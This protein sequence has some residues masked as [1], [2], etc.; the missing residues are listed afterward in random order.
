[1]RCVRHAQKIK[2]GS[3]RF[4][5]VGKRAHVGARFQCSALALENT[6][7]G[8]VHAKR[9]S[10]KSCHEYYLA[11]ASAILSVGVASLSTSEPSLAEGE[12]GGTTDS[13]WGDEAKRYFVAQ[14][15]RERELARQRGMRGEIP[16]VYVDFSSEDRCVMKFHVSSE[17]GIPT[18]ASL[19]AALASSS[20][21]VE[22]ARCDSGESVIKLVDKSRN[23]AYVELCASPRGVVLQYETKGAI[24]SKELD[25]VASAYGISIQSKNQNPLAAFEMFNGE[26][27]NAPWNEGRRTSAKSPEERLEDLGVTVYR[28]DDGDVLLW[29][30]L[31]G[32]DHIRDQ[33][34][35]SVLLALQHPRAYDDVARKTRQ[36]FETNRPRAIL[37][38]GLPGTGKTLTARI[39]A[40]HSKVNMVYLPV[41]SV[42]S[43][44]YGES[45]KKL[46]EIFEACEE[47]GNC[48]IFLDEIDS[49][50]TS[51]DGDMHEATRRLLS[52]LLRKLE[53][54]DTTSSSSVLI[55][56]TNR[57]DDLDAALIS[58]FD[59]TIRFSPPDESA[60]F[61]IFKYYAKQLADEEIAELATLSSGLVARDI[62]HACELAERVHVSR[63]L[64]GASSLTSC[65]SIKEY[66]TAVRARLAHAGREFV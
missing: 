23:D 62:K 33:V 4:V 17:G 31:A 48:I 58:R 46:A 7:E 20:L 50:A 16:R 54:F 22:T 28:R 25:A 38:E 65:P 39:C 15:Q 19:C 24:T 27:M 61:Q 11:A 21:T 59:M 47:L 52:V 32:Y 57:K 1:M 37:F 6:C 43:K 42:M 60:R 55:A 40:N 53:G 3:T 66:K 29:D 8:V 13:L 56:A 14:I 49:L 12:S 5:A 26:M 10:G 2:I 44:W 64:K 45:E 41:E 9:S 30:A 18:L 35:S 63:G 34:E 51:R 36:K